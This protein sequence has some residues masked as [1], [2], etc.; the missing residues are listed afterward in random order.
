[1]SGKLNSILLID[2]D[3]ITTYYNRVVIEDEEITDLIV[4]KYSAKDAIAY[5]EETINPIPE[6]II[7]DINMPIMSGWEFIEYIKKNNTRGVDIFKIFML[8]ASMSPDDEKKAEVYD[9]ICG[10]LIKPLE[11]D[12]MM[13][14]YHKN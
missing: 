5:L 13:E 12:K 11:V 7:V 4:E 6:I 2:N 3:D 1:M 8:T 9:F 10:F 14:L